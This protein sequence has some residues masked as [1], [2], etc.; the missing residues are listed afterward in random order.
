LSNGGS[1]FESTQAAMNFMLSQMRIETIN[2]VKLIKLLKSEN[3]WAKAA[4]KFDSIRID[5]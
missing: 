1:T 3:L 2:E 4:E 5:N